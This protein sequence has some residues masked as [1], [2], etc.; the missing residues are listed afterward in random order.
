MTPPGFRG[1]TAGIERLEENLRVVH[2]SD[3]EI[4]RLL[5][6]AAAFRDRRFLA[7]VHLL[8]DTGARVQE[9]ARDHES[10]DH[11]VDVRGHH[12]HRAATRRAGP[13]R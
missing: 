8:H 6:G 4:K 13:H 2:L 9:H 12:D 10:D 3:D 7:Y 11:R 5:A 1:P